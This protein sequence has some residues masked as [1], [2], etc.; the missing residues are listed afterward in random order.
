[1]LQVEAPDEDSERAH[2]YC[3]QS[4][5]QGPWRRKRE[6]E[7]KGKGERKKIE[8]AGAVA[9]DLGTVAWIG[10][11]T[12]PRP[13]AAGAGGASKAASSRL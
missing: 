3:L 8:L 10:V 13:L 9:V 2:F 1:M 6:G 12:V 11:A 7:R 4:Q 5:R